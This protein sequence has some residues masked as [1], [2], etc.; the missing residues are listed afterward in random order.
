[1]AGFITY[2]PKEYVKN[3]NWA[4]RQRKTF[5]AGIIFSLMGERIDGNMEWNQK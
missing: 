3:L 5:E 1:M 4:K 2:W